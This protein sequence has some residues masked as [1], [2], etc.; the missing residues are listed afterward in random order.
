MRM[1][2]HYDDL[3]LLKPAHVDQFTDYR[4]Y[5]IEQLPR[6]NRILVL[7]DLGLPLEQIADLLQKDLP[8]EQLQHLLRSKQKDLQQQLQDTQSRLNRVSARLQQLEQEGQPSAYDVIVKSVPA[9]CIASTRCTVPSAAEMPKYRGMLIRQLY[10]WLKQQNI[11]PSGYE[12][13][14]YHISE[15]TETNIDMEFAIA[16]PESTQLTGDDSQAAIAVRQLP[17]LNQVASIVHS[18]MLR[19]ITQAIAAL[20]TWIGT[21]GYTSSGAIRE[22]HLFGLETLRVRDE[23]VVVELQISI[24]PL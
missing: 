5:T 24:E 15:Y 12:I 22:I 14:L 11:T 23:P 1:L 19:E 3:G 6:L 20:F 16:I 13:V 8:L 21:N 7:K 17:A 2:R 18:G 4:Y 9:C 10:A